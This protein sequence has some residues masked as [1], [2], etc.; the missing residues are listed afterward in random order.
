MLIHIVKHLHAKF[1]G[2]QGQVAQSKTLIAQQ[3]TV[4][5]KWSFDSQKFKFL[6]NILF[7]NHKH[8]LINAWSWFSKLGSKNHQD[9]KVSL[10][11]QLKKSTANWPGHN[12]HMD[13]QKNSIQSSF[14][15]ESNFLQLL[16]TL[17]VQ[18]ML[19]Q[20]VI[21]LNIIGHFQKSTKR[22]FKS[23]T[24]TWDW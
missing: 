11:G 1:Q 22:H 21:N 9:A 15:R 20:K 16:F 5:A 17:Q 18:E 13:Y 14:W 24:I 3:S 12:F 8:H 10:F 4:G 2:S 6:V 19:S 23:K 7:W